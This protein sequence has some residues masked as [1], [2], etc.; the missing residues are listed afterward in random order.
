[1]T[2]SDEWLKALLDEKAPSELTTTELAALHER[3]AASPDVR[4][5]ILE[6]IR[7]EES[8]YAALAS[9]N[10]SGREIVQRARRR[11][12]NRI[13]SFAAMFF[14]LIAGSGAFWLAINGFEGLKLDKQPEVVADNE[15]PDPSEPRDPP[16]GQDETPTTDDASIEATRPTP[17]IAT[18]K[19]IPQEAEAVSPEPSVEPNP[20]D[21]VLGDEAP[22]IPFETSAFASFGET[23]PGFDVADEFPPL[24]LRRWVS[25][26]AG[27]PLN[28]SEGQWRNKKFASLEG[29]AKVIPP[30]RDDAVLRVA[31]FDVAEF[32]LH[33]WSGDQGI[34]VRFYPHQR[35]QLLTAYAIGRDAQEPAPAR[36]QLLATDG[37]SYA[38]ANAGA[39][40]IRH[41]NEHL[42]V[43]HGRLP[44]LVVPLHSPP[45]EI[46]VEGRMKLRSLAMYRGESAPVLASAPR[47]SV[48]P[49][50]PLDKHEWRQSEE[51]KPVFETAPDRIT[52][53][54]PESAQPKSRQAAWAAVS[55]PPDQ[56][57]GLCEAVFQLAELTPGTGVYL[58][59]EN[60][61]PL[62]TL[63]LTENQ[64]LNSPMVMYGWTS[65]DG[66]VP[67]PRWRW[68]L[69]PKNELTPVV[70]PGSWLKLVVGVG[71][72]KAYISRDGEHWGPCSRSPER[73]VRGP[74]RSVGLFAMADGKPRTIALSNLQV[75][76]LSGI[77]SAASNELRAR[78]P[79]PKTPLE[80]PADWLT[81]VMATQP[82]NV[83]TDNWLR[84]CSVESLARGTS[85]DS[86]ST[87]I[88]D[89]LMAHSI[90][91]NR[92]LD[93][94]LDLLADAALLSDTWNDR[95]RQFLSYY[96]KL[97]T[98]IAQNESAP[99]TAATDL[100]RIA[101]AYLLAPIWTESRPWAM[102]PEIPRNVAAMAVWSRE[103]AA[104]LAAHA[105]AF[106]LTP[107]HPERGWSTDEELGLTRIV[108]WAAEVAAAGDQQLDGASRFGWG[109]PLT[110]EPGREA[111]AVALE[112]EAALTAGA[113]AD[114]ARLLGTMTNLSGLMPAPSDPDRFIPPP[115]LI[116]EIA[117]QHPSLTETIQQES[118]AVALL[119]V[120]QAIATKDDAAVRAA[121][122]RYIGTPAAVE[123]NQWLGDAALALG[124]FQEAVNH[125]NDALEAAS[126]EQ[127]V[128]LL[129][130]QQL[131]QAL[132]GETSAVE[133]VSEASFGPQTL[134]QAQFN[135]LIEDLRKSSASG[136]ELFPI[137]QKQIPKAVAVS[138]EAR[139][140]FDGDLGRNPGKGEFRRFDWVGRQISVTS[141][142]G[143]LYLTNRFQVVA[144]DSKR[145]LP[146]WTV[147]L[148]KEQGE[149][150]SWPNV[151]FKPLAV[152]DRLFVRRLNARAPELACLQITNRGKLV[153]KTNSDIAV[154]SDPIFIDGGLFALTAP[155][156]R[157]G[158][159]LSTLS[160]TLFRPDDGTPIFSAPLIVMSDPDAMQPPV[161]LLPTEDGVIFTTL[162]TAARCD[163]S[164]NILWVRKLPFLPPAA[165]PDFDRL[166]YSRPIYKE[167]RLVIAPPGTRAVLALDAETGRQLWVKP[168]GELEGLCGLTNSV[169][170]LKSPEAIIGLDHSTGET[171]WTYHRPNLLEGLLC[172]ETT[173][174]AS[175]RTA[176]ADQQDG[177]ALL[178]IDSTNGT[179]LSEQTIRV[180][181]KEEIH[182]GPLIIEN[183]RVWGFVGEGW[184]DPKRTLVEFVPNPSLPSVEPAAK[185]DELYHWLS[186]VDPQTLF[187]AATVL[188]GW[189][190]IGSQSAG[191]SKNG[192][193]FL[194]QHQGESW[195]LRTKAGRDQAT[196]FLKTITLPAG[197]PKL[198][199]RVGRSSDQGWTLRLLVDGRP[200]AS[201]PISKATAPEGW[202]TVS[203]DLSRFAGQ[204]VR[205]VLEQTLPAE[206]ANRV[207]EAY[208]K[209]LAIE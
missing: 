7:L 70:G 80:R 108:S 5:A 6:R 58:G 115:R 157:R 74:F 85:P 69:D 172:D 202:R 154:V 73:A 25:D 33:F 18:T 53:S 24:E 129:A 106:Y 133:Q 41:Q 28:I 91:S 21:R 196:Q 72:L 43:T 167:G 67:E 149:A 158:G 200:I 86:I 2:S 44:L 38:R 198:K 180:Q 194:D 209:S 150:H 146:L 68:D 84:A 103:D 142:R 20:W 40:E 136:N 56:P 10:V 189:T 144:F 159:G 199:A 162:G 19:D 132:T 79:Q 34:S 45:Q 89:G 92:P 125:F 112:L 35:P 75:R 39:I 27:L 140:R 100:L 36:F 122:L 171:K 135:D 187:N 55:L 152:N 93:A 98:H 169:V 206:D 46:I 62:H 47:R 182:C 139:G 201:E 160:L 17:N 107:S 111:T 138:P 164:G 30:W 168:L 87:V 185:A 23:V 143:I 155:A 102:P 208:W 137:P 127:R 184:R 170:V 37:G 12:R 13:I 8:L 57:S 94:T 66:S 119:A 120:R 3:A 60:G 166:P 165:D 153:W 61:V 109:H 26:V 95:S 197:Q 174:L 78:V 63:F 90:S 22:V 203:F 65:R 179:R 99:A 161:E 4:Q 11:R 124:Q 192:A 83:S 59:D 116:S 148:G 178:R 64:V 77:A 97:A 51:P 175:S 176:L 173:V 118:G 181:R 96:S 186:L 191:N 110:T 130:R 121:A 88:L 151:T 207:S 141:D 71:G 29:F 76:E 16:T 101:E 126:P 131:A 52:L 15:D 177:L 114:A 128:A 123:A 156:D 48:L 205:L 188:P 49:D 104:A 163:W 190:P 81:W 134:S 105:T 50:V 145:N 193:D 195:V 117:T 32:A 183:D 1:M 42:V 147:G 31:P 113:Y 204:N 9:P 54:L 82:D 14:L